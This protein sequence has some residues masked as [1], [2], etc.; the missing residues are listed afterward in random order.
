MQP[1]TK[2]YEV[3]ETLARGGMG[4][5]SVARERAGDVFERLVVLKTVLPDRAGDHELA[6][7]L[8]D[9]ARVLAQLQHPNIAQI[10]DVAFL[11]RSLCIV[12]EWLRGHTLSEIARALSRRKT[13]MSVETA[14]AILIGAASGLEYAHTA[15]DSRGRALGV[16]HRDVSPQNVFLTRDGTVKLID[17]GIALSSQ[18]R[19][20]STVHGVV[21][22]KIRYMAPE[23]LRGLGADARSDVWALGV[24]AWE[25]LTGHRLFPPDDA[26]YDAILEGPIAP[27]SH[28]GA[29]TDPELDAIV[30]VMLERDPRR[31]TQS[32]GELR[33][34]LLAWSRT[35]RIPTS[36]ELAAWFAEVFPIGEDA[37]PGRDARPTAT[38]CLVSAQ[39][40]P[41]LGGGTATI[42][43]PRPP[44]VPAVSGTRELPR[45]PDPETTAIITAPRRSPEL[46][47]RAQ[48]SPRRT[49]FA[50]G[51]VTSVL[52]GIAVAVALLASSGDDEELA[53]PAPPPL[54]TPSLA[55]PAPRQVRFSVE[56]LPDGA[57]LWLAGRRVEGNE[58]TVAHG[59]GNHL[60][61]ARD[62]SGATLFSQT[63]GSEADVR[64]PF[65]ARAV[66]SATP[67]RPSAGRPTKAPAKTTR[68]PSKLVTTIDTDYP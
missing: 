52:V 11:D 29:Q 32:C 38:V 31:R 33:R 35:R 44:A 37:E 62:A 40:E 48:R 57:T 4:E 2:S 58:V 64:I 54:A 49:A 53:A 1:L 9:E 36:H 16:V 22:G 25:L 13:W 42:E 41:P 10:H 51:G 60:L 68:R 63:L 12:M 50:V 19:E 34:A 8:L 17:F 47:P 26:A 6:S 15:T 39:P 43:P 56:G 27:P 46:A 23:Q 45:A 21:K 65:V 59:S 14:V 20:A 28:R 67:E 7:A 5:V 18:R 66:A 24:V 55:P 30:M 3:L 61:E